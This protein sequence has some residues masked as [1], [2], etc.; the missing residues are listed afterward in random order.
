MATPEAVAEEEEVPLAEAPPVPPALAEAVALEL[1]VPLIDALPAVPLA[2]ADAV[3][4]LSPLADAV[5][6][7]P[8]EAVL[9]AV[10]LAVLE[11]VLEAASLAIPKASGLPSLAAIASG[12]SGTLETGVRCALTLLAASLAASARCWAFKAS[13]LACLYSAKF[14]P[15]KASCAAFFAFNNWSSAA[16]STSFNRPF[17]REGDES[18]PPFK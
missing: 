7:P 4:L 8:T 18:T 3:P 5:P 16:F 9:E 6:V 10:L 15:S 17:S 12:L 11:A 2:V 1:A 13:S 14:P